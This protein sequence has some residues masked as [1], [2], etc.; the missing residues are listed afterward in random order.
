M[1]ACWTRILLR[2]NIQER[3]LVTWLIV[4]C[5]NIIIIIIIIIIIWHYN[6]LRVFAFSAKP[7]QALLSLAASFRSKGYS[8][9]NAAHIGSKEM[10]PIWAAFLCAYPLLHP[11]FCPQKTHNAT[12][13]YRGTC[14]QGRRH[15]VT[16]ATS[17]QS[18]AY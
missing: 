7:L 12:L 11:Y 10:L 18:C 6:S 4:L 5:C 3:Y 8:Q 14:I 2:W 17:V 1:V 13:F 16:A 15:L 9:R